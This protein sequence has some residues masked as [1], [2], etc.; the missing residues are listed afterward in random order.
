MS[1]PNEERESHEADDVADIGMEDDGGYETIEDVPIIDDIEEDTV[2]GGGE[3]D[4]ED[5]EAS[6]I[7]RHECSRDS[8]F[9]QKD[10]ALGSPGLLDTSVE[11]SPSIPDDTPSIRGS[12]ASSR[13]SSALI[14]QASAPIHSPSPSLRPFDRRFQ[15]RLSPSPASSPR[16]LS[17]AFLNS[18]SR[19]S[20]LASQLPLSIDGDESSEPPW[21]IIRWTKL[22]KIT[23]QVFSE[24][25]KRNFGRATF[26]AVSSLIAIG[27]SK[28]LVLIFDYHQSLRAVIGQGTKAVESGPVSALAISADHTTIAAGHNDG[29]IYT[30]EIARPSNPFLQIPS[31][32]RRQPSLSHFD[33]HVPGSAVLH[34]G[35]LGTRHT[36]LVSA[37]ERG[38][39][40]SHLA[41]RG[42]G[43]VA[44]IVK[45]TRILGRYPENMVPLPQ[46]RK[47]KPSSVLAFAPLPLGNAEQVTDDMGL[48]AMLTPYLLVIVSTTPIAQTQH[49]VSRPKEL[50]SLHGTM[51]AALAW[52]PAVKLK[53]K[54]PN[55]AGSVSR[56][57][58]AYSW[59]NILTIL[60][61]T[62]EEPSIEGGRDKPPVLQFN[63]RRRWKADE[64]IVAIQWLGRTVLGILT[65]TQRLLI[66]ED[67]SMNVTGS[68]DLLQRH[69]FHTD[70]FSA[71]LNQLVE[72]LDEEDPSMHGV[73]ADAFHMSFRAYKGRMFLLGFNDMA[74]GTLS[75]W[76]DRLVALMEAGDYIGAIGL[77][78][79]YYRGEAE[80]QT[81]GLPEDDASRH[82]IVRDKLV[83]M[84]SASLKYAFMTEQKREEM[85]G[86][87]EKLKDLA[88]VCFAA[89]ISIDDMDF[90]FEDVYSWFEENET[91]GIFLE[92]LEP[93]IL[94]YEIRS[95]PPAVLKT[96]VSHYTKKGSEGR[97]EELICRLDTSTMDLDQVTT[98]CKR[99]RLYDAFIYVWNRALNDYITPLEYLIKLASQQAVVVNGNSTKGFDITNASKI[100]PYLSYIFT[101]RIYPTG[102]Q[103]DDQEANIA[104]SD[105][106]SFLFSGKTSASDSRSQHFPH[107]REIL[108]FDAPSF[109]SMLNE[110]FE[111]SFLNGLPDSMTNGGPDHGGGD[112]QNTGMSMNRQ[113]IIRILLE[114]MHSGKYG[115]ED[116][117]YLDMFIA[118][119]LPKFP[120]FILLPGKT[121]HEVLVRLCHYAAPDIA[122]DCQLSVEYL[123]SLYHPPDLQSLIP[124]FGDA[125]FY[126]VLK[127]IYR[128]EKQ[129]TQLIQTCFADHQ[130]EN[131]LFDCIAEC[132]GPQ[133]QATEKQR[134]E[135]RD[136]LKSHASELLV[137]DVERTAISIESYMP[138]LHEDFL[139]DLDGRQRAQF[140]YLQA[141]L[142]PDIRDS[143]HTRNPSQQL[144]RDFIEQ[145][146]R[147][148]CECAPL[149][150]TEYIEV[151]KS[152]DLRLEEVLPSM[153]ASGIVDAAVVL[154]ARQGQVQDAMSR[155][156]EHLSALEAVLTG[157]LDSA[158]KSPDAASTREAVN[159]LLESLQ[160]YVKV[161]VWLCRGQS[162]TSTWSAASPSMA[163]K[164]SKALGQQLSA[165]ETLWLDLIDVTVRIAKNVSAA[166]NR[167]PVKQ[168]F[169]SEQSIPD[170]AI[171]LRTSVQQVF[172]ALL[173]HT[174]SGRNS[175]AGRPDLS[176]LRI[177]R[178]FLTRASVSSP[179][180]S[181]LR[182]VLA[183]I[184]SAYAYEE[185]LLSLANSMLD[186]DLFI[187]VD[188]ATKLRQRGW[189][190]LG[191][192][193]ESCKK[194]VW[195]PGI[196][197][198]VWKAWEAKNQQGEQQRRLKW[199]KRS[200]IEG[201]RWERGKGRAVPDMTDSGHIRDSRAEQA[202]DAQGEGQG[203]Q[204]GEEELGPLVV[205]SCR[206]LFH[207]KCLEEGRKREDIP[208]GVAQ[209]HGMELEFSCPLCT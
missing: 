188:E 166:I 149:H 7:I 147:L 160:K 124:L 25:G 114:V 178:A 26:L 24:L 180:L 106:Y 172:T 8:S 203:S 42:M 140:V 131:A 157:L 179:S 86:S 197:I 2:V 102:E 202:L 14:S 59:S 199:Q 141:I 51:C 118:R 79:I 40:F 85:Q 60:E 1:A 125:R 89:C 205:L 66:I 123:L 103:L 167:D 50:A 146:V 187:H 151:L 122:D 46:P 84:M 126:R 3:R 120:Q 177:L 67:S 209:V 165:D 15:A 11:D 30:W 78:T 98:L 159:D 156:V 191:Q 164:T 150:V 139:R 77:A 168:I 116:T 152:S 76:A 55:A 138:A 22:R 113:Y 17:P 91:E 136:V 127:S 158:T 48:V 162:K 208:S 171:S 81:V 34:V 57:K 93:Y 104:K 6:S 145:Y 129:Y 195:G 153:E 29:S 130:N 190:P 39:A 28:G 62:E 192:V 33:G 94:D 9:V 36:A 107:L 128:A 73:V 144:N 43:A 54:D 100:F 19:Q 70:L 173:N 185:S 71:Q 64:A 31:I 112:V 41:T 204:D 169:S 101:G 47:P 135:I 87:E 45:T 182:S 186:K 38:M 176:F 88:R 37:D 4:A 32:D 119:N 181:E 200:A 65:L 5:G 132:L 206:H 193:C 10:K 175:S 18:H 154:L 109:L 143:E 69:I 142:E 110:A 161:G 63:A 44:R 27:T 174:T 75:N 196:G 184:F 52:F 56:T 117:V 68:F 133:S 23:G 72:Q 53:V 49:K 137:V 148:M 105:L 90:L 20:S 155:L 183:A 194:R 198:R 21:E 115:P 74:I 134:R 121:L 201:D 16:L 13:P 35:F 82:A 170:L 12:A 163:M 96:L 80:K 92:V 99:Y 83:E 95:V 111:D 97:L 58:L 108:N 207:R 61:V 189:R